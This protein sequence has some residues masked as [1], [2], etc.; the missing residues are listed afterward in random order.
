MISII[1]FIE[2][3]EQWEIYDLLGSV[4]LLTYRWNLHDLYSLDAPN[5]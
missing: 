4:Q 3:I 2:S 1:Y 5:K